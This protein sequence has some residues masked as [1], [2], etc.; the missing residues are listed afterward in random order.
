MRS[1]RGAMLCLAACV[2]P[3]SVA[4]QSYNP[5]GPQ[6]NVPVSTVEG[7]GWV[8]CFSSTYDAATGE[9][10]ATI[11]AQCTGSRLMLACAPVGA[12]DL[13][14]LSQ[15]TAAEAFTDPGVGS[16][17]SHVA[18][19]AQW[20]FNADDAGGSGS[21]SWGFAAAGDS[22][23]RDNCDTAT[24]ASPELRLCWHLNGDAGGYRCGSTEDL[25]GSTAWVKYVYTAGA[26]VPTMN[27]W[28]IALVALLMS[29]AAAALLRRRSTGAALS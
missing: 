16:T 25:N 14:L 10:L 9:D 6:T 7:G 1:A 8:E 19:G 21:G 15:A 3:V 12:T 23:S 26:V 11:Q 24:G 27:Q 18:N 28:Q 20:Y 29:I 5:V 22:L 13:T 4:A 17:D 2:L